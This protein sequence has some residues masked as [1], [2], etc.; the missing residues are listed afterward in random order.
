M[1]W[2]PSCWSSVADAVPV[3]KAFMGSTTQKV[4]LA[5]TMPVLVVMPEG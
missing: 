3:G 1:T 5:A 4:I 2:M